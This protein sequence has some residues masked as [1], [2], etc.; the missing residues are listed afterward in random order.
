MSNAVYLWVGFNIFL[1]AMLAIDLFLFH[2]KAHQVSLREALLMSAGWIGLA[3]AFN[4]AVY[5]AF[6]R[7]KALEF[8]TGYLMEKSLSVDNIFVFLLIFRYFK[9]SGAQQ[10][11]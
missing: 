2:K 8:L 7:E 4:V 11:D 6:G 1:L 9:V 10:H 3:L 5:Y